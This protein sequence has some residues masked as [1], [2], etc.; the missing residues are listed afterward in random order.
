MDPLDKIAERKLDEAVREGRFDDY[1]G[2]GEPLELEDLSALD[3]DV[4]ASYLVLKGH[5]YLS[6]E[7]GLRLELV[8]LDGLLAACRDDG[9]R[10]ALSAKRSSTAV[11]LALLLEKRGSSA[12]LHEFREQLARFGERGEPESPRPDPA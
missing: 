1:P 6:E 4:R 12:L 10:G 5:G 8:R 11:R 9:E 3:E 7:A 2:K